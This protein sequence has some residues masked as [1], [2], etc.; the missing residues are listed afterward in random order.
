MWAVRRNEN[1]LCGEGNGKGVTRYE[2]DR[3]REWTVREEGMR[4]TEHGMVV[5]YG[6]T[7]YPY[8]LNNY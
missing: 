3:T 1:G 2:N 8:R 5:E 4:M 7:G 6:M